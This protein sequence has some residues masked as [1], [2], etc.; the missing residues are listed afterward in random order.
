MGAQLG[1]TVVV[2]VALTPN[3][4]AE[5][6]GEGVEYSFKLGPFKS[7]RLLLVPTYATCPKERERI[8]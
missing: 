8:F 6:A 7:E 3:F 2:V 1:V 5:L 4:H